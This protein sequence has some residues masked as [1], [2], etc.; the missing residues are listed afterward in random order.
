MFVPLK[1][2]SAPDMYKHHLDQL[3]LASVFM[4]PY[5]EYHVICLFE[6]V[7]LY[8]GWLRY[9]TRKVRYLL[10]RV[11]RQFGY[12]QTI[13]RSPLESAPVEMAL[14][15]TSYRYAHNVDH[16]LRAPKLG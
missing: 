15:E 8:Y 14:S 12:T 7:S 9:G 10:E 13:P 6:Q 1:G 5:A 4:S 16:V 3:D 11:L 2:M